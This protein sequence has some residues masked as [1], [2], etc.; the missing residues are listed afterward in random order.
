MHQ[1][2]YVICVLPPKQEEHVPAFMQRPRRRLFDLAPEGA[3]DGKEA[4]EQARKLMSAGVV[5]PIGLAVNVRHV[6][7][8][9][10]GCGMPP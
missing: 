4:A 2:A 3:V 9:L 5:N 8:G 10:V 6:G 7:S 1:W